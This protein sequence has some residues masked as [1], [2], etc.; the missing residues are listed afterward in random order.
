LLEQIGVPFRVV[1]SGISE[2]RLTGESPEAYVAR[3]AADKADEVWQRVCAAEPAP[4]L[5]AD[6]AVVVDQQVF[7]KPADSAEALDML[8]R[9]SGRSH[10]VLTAVALRWQS[11]RAGHVSCSEVRFR[12]TTERERIAYCRT[13][14][15]YDKAGGYAIQGLG[16]LFVEYLAGSYSAVMGLPLLETASLLKRFELPRWLAGG[17]TTSQ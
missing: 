4:V 3:M 1:A 13:E 5:A 2:A 7:G 15:S 14:E 17:A 11:D 9:L 12:A 16:G 8:A 10:T 6:T